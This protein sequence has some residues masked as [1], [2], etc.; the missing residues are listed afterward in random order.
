MSPESLFGKNQ[1]YMSDFYSI[2]VIGYE[3]LMRERPY[4]SI[5]RNDLRNEIL[6]K[7][8]F[9]D[10][11]ENY[12]YS[13]NCINFINRLLEKNPIKRLGYYNNVKELINNYWLRDVDWKELYEKKIYSPFIEIINSSKR[14]YQVNELYDN[15]FDDYQINEENYHQFNKISKKKYNKLFKNY[16]CLCIGYNNINNYSNFNYENDISYH[17]L[18]KKSYSLK[19]IILRS[20]R[21][22]E[23]INPENLIFKIPKE[24][25]NDEEEV[26]KFF[27]TPSI[28]RFSRFGDENFNINNKRIIIKPIIKH[29]YK[30]RILHT[31]LSSKKM[32]QSKSNNFFLNGKKNNISNEEENSVNDY[33]KKYLF[34]PI[35]NYG[36]SFSN[37]NRSKKVKRKFF[38]NES[39][40]SFEKKNHTKIFNKRTKYDKEES[41]LPEISNSSPMKNKFTIKLRLKKPKKLL[42]NNN[43]NE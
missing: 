15:D 32:N 43:N 31:P 11:D 33:F 4:Y 23:R 28:Q 12:N 9:I 8:A 36:F 35:N 22:I 20:D 37:D 18:G 5:K 38:F 24:M 34:L 30:N 19:H 41:E 10:Y 21:I 25:Y 2:G 14:K 26:L 17:S 29:K 40:T 42:P 7:Q 13:D 6:S 3:L 27:Y 16:D 39:L 1:T